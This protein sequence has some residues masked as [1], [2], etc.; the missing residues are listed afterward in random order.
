MATRTKSEALLSDS[1][2][3]HFSN[4]GD[5]HFL[6]WHQKNRDSFHGECDMVL[7][8]DDNFNDG[9]GLDVH[10]RTTI[11]K[12]YSYVETAAIRIGEAIVEFQHDRLLMG[13]TEYE[14]GALPLVVSDGDQEFT[15]V[16]QYD[17]FDEQTDK[18]LRVQVVLSETRMLTFA[19][20]RSLC[21]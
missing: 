15:I 16:K 12:F 19:S 20:T 10:I 3:T 13:G 21:T 8:H 1:F 11:S 2:V 14:Y 7:L 9:R 4:I 5:P 18:K 6:R 17:H